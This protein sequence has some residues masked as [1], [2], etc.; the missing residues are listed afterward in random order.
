MDKILQEYYYDPENSGSLGGAKKLHDK[1]KKDGKRIS[2]G[3]VKQWLKGQRA[4]TLHRQPRRNFQRNKILA[5]DRNE[6]WQADLVDMMA[7]A[8]END[9]FKHLLT[10]IDVLSKQAYRLVFFFEKGLLNS[11]RGKACIKRACDVFIVI[12]PR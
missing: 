2:I 9:N 12:R 3:K 4:Y 1:L 11:A 7:L 8:R 10:V 6:I 5:Y